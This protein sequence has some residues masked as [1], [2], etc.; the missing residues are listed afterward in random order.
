[1]GDAKS[2]EAGVPTSQDVTPGVPELSAY[3]D[4]M[5]N[6]ISSVEVMLSRIERTLVTATREKGANPIDAGGTI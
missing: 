5:V 3:P 4:P 2:A 1:L 6:S